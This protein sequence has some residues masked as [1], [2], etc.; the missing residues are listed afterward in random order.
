M[1][2][3]TREKRFALPNESQF[4]V[5]NCDKFVIPNELYNYIKKHCSARCIRNLRYLNK[6]LKSH[7]EYVYGMLG[8]SRNYIWYDMKQNTYHYFII[9]NKKI[10]KDFNYKKM[11]ILTVTR[12]NIHKLPVLFDDINLDKAFFTNVPMLIYNFSG[13]RSIIE[14]FPIYNPTDSDCFELWKI[15][16]KFMTKILLFNVKNHPD[17]F[18][19]KLEMEFNDFRQLIKRQTSHKNQSILVIKIVIQ[20]FFEICRTKYRFFYNMFN[21]MNIR[22]KFIS[23]RSNFL[24]L[25]DTI[26]YENDI[27][28]FSL[29]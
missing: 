8:N 7:F 2:K 29:I 27:K 10:F 16:G 28:P 15:F 19:K 5:E 17:I 14:H 24:I 6:N 11:L 3:L 20:R 12:L 26:I 4:S 1:N 25:N 21:S 22:V 13:K 23:T 18:D 9:S